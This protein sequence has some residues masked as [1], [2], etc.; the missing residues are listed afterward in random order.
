MKVIKLFGL[1]LLPGSTT[2]PAMEV[3]L[4]ARRL[5]P[6]RVMPICQVQYTVSET[7]EE[8]E[9]VGGSRL[10]TP[11]NL[12]SDLKDD[13]ETLGRAYQQSSHFIQTTRLAPL[14]HLLP[15]V[16]QPVSL[17]LRS[18]YPECY[19]GGAPD[20]LLT[21]EHGSIKLPCIHSAFHRLILILSA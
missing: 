7:E 4:M 18:I 17:T 15:A 16:S 14:V 20:L 6:T 10:T 19:Q 1:I 2:A 21:G 5:T 9:T 3:L 8:I 11:I 12:S 13:T